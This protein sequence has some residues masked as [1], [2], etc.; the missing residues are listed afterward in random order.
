M[1]TVGFIG[2][3]SIMQLRHVPEA[4]LNRKCAIS[5]F[6]NRRRSRAK[7]LADEYGGQVYGTVEE[8][9]ADATVQC[10]VIATANSLHAPLTI[11]ALK[12]GKHVL[13]EKP[14]A[15]TIAECEEMIKAAQS[16]GRKLMLAH[17][18]RLEPA[19]KLAK[20]ILSSGRLGA[21]TS[22]SAVMANRG[23]EL[24]GIDKSMTSWFY[25][26]SNAVFGAIGDL[27]VHKV[28][29][30][31]WLLDDEIDEVMAYL[32]TVDKRRE[33]GELVDLD[34][35]AV[36]VMRTRRGVVGTLTA[37]WTFYG[38][39][40]YG[41]VIQCTEGTLRIY[42]DPDCTVAVLKR[43]GDIEKYK[44]YEQTVGSERHSGMMDSF[45]ESIEKDSEPVVTGRDGLAAMRIV[46]AC[47][48]SSKTGKAVRPSELDTPISR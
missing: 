17:N 31:R 9:L 38:Q 13:C 27:G 40:E 1:V 39:E 5:G 21:V 10:V 6:Y 8:M 28:D 18:M 43:N 16:T 35:I 47:V 44:P 15:A 29:L 22:F 32:A 2:A 36:A 4:R 14:M 41:T 3:G 30:M 11:Q 33:S 19:S 26:R 46:L 20:D 34:D 42:E 12:A 23:P 37:A 45:I 7:N 24:W 25:D 48:Q